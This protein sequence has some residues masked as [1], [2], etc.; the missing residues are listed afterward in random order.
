MND[1]III[2]LIICYLEWE[3]GMTKATKTAKLSDE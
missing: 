1:I 3:R 2:I